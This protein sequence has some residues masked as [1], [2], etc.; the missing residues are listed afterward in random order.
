MK[1]WRF[2]AVDYRS[3]QNLVMG[4]FTLPMTASNLE[5]RQTVL[6]IGT[7]AAEKAEADLLEQL[8]TQAAKQNGAVTGMADTYSAINF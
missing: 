7:A 2:S 5:V 1:M 4:V 3:W 8:L 6:R